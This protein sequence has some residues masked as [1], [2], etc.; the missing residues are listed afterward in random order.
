MQEKDQLEYLGVGV[1]M[2]LKLMLK[3]KHGGLDSC[4]LELEQVLG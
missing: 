2:I 4:G 3:G 1:M